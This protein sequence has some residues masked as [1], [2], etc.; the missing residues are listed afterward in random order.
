MKLDK[1]T[2]NLLSKGNAVVAEVFENETNRM[3][4]SIFPKIL[5][6]QDNGSKQNMWNTYHYEFIIL[7]LK[8]GW[9]SNKENWKSFEEDKVSLTA[10]TEKEFQSVTDLLNLSKYVFSD[11]EKGECPI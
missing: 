4:V 1:K 10:T 3:F 9:E 5:K 8:P 11:Y 6:K 7:E 2:L